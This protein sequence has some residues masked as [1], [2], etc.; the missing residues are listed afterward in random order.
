MADSGPDRNPRASLVANQDRAVVGRHIRVEMA[1]RGLTQGKLAEIAAYDER[2]IRNVLKGL[3][4]KDVTLY[5]VCAS[6]DIDLSK[7]PLSK[8]PG[9]ANHSAIPQSHGAAVGI[10]PFANISGDAH[11]DYFVDGIV[12]DIIT[13]LSRFSEL[14]VIARNSTF[15]YKG[16]AIDVRQVGR[17]L[18]AQY[19]VEGSVRRS[20]Q[21]VR[22]TT[23]LINASSGAHLWAERYDR[24]ISDVFLVQDEV[25]RAIASVLVAHVNKAEAARIL[26]K[27]PEA[28]EAYDC[29]LRA[30]DLFSSFPGSIDVERIYQAR[31][32]LD[33]ALS[34]DETYARAHAMLSATHM[35]TWLSALDSDL[36][37]PAAL[38][39]AYRAA[40][41]AVQ[42]DPNLPQARGQLGHVLLYRRE[43]DAAIAEFERARALNPNFNDWRYALAMSVP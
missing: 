20:K 29:Y 22:I 17:D 19:V 15:Q 39:R 36:L 7:L 31:R 14:V 12:E 35:A 30:A 5:E 23:Q 8:P 41:R 4:V 2:T 13:E 28:W 10:L 9:S 27:P 6:L 34:L 43:H 40:Q 32:L 18:G 33:R 16:R 21:R 37:N 11:Q 25:A 3:P 38:E 24:E 26:A 42:L 1:R